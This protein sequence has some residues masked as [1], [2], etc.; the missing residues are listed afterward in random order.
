LSAFIRFCT[1]RD[2]PQGVKASRAFA[3]LRRALER[4]L[5]AGKSGQRVSKVAQDILSSY[6]CTRAQ[7]AARR[8]SELGDEVQAPSSSKRLAAPLCSLSL[9]PHPSGV[10]VACSILEH[11]ALARVSAG[12]L[13]KALPP[14][15]RPD[16]SSR[17]ARR[18]P[19]LSQRRIAE[20]LF[21]SCSAGDQFHSRSWDDRLSLPNS[22]RSLLS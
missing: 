18:L 20:Q 10:V 4:W 19:T 1:P 15:S 21:R 12:L 7:A 3:T 22:S 16:S 14:G 8:Q 13:Q 9:L 11:G 2:S 5:R 17:S 6:E